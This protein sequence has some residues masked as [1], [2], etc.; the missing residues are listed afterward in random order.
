MKNALKSI[1]NR[2]G[3]MEE[4]ISELKDSNI[5]VFQVEKER[6]LRFFKSEETPW[7]FSDSIRRAN[8]RLMSIP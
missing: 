8:I 1:G 2:A 3:Q 4:R 5:E 6:E 7:E